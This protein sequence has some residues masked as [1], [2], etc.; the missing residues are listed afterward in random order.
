[1][2]E[3]I[4]APTEGDTVVIVEGDTVEA[5]ETP[6]PPVE[7]GDNVVIV[8]ES[9]DAPVEVVIDH[10]ERI[11]TLEA[12]LEQLRGETWQAQG[13]A[14][15]AMIVAESVGEQSQE[16]DEAIVAAVDETVEDIEEQ[17]NDELVEDSGILSDPD[18]SEPVIDVAPTSARVHPLFRSLSQWKE[19]N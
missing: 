3:P 2:P 18:D 1:M 7:T 10:A 5:N 9:N 4:E 15:A 12:E 14:D 16:T 8:E 13:T 17:V 19:G 11:A 6:D